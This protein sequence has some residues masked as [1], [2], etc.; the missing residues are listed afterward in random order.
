MRAA[1]IDAWLI[2]DFRGN[3][4]ALARVLQAK[5]WTTRRAALLI[6]R[7]GD[8]TL[9]CHAIDQGQLTPHFPALKVYTSWQ[10]F[11]ALLR[12]SLSGY[13]RVAMEYAPGA[14]LPVVG[15]VDAGTV[16]LIRSFGVEVVSSADLAQVSIARWDDAAQKNH[17]HAS[18]ITTSIM[19]GA[20]E[21]IRTQRKAGQEIREHQVQRY[22]V[23]RFRSEG[24]EFGE[25][26]IV[27]VNEHGSDPH[28][29]VSEKT[30]K[31]VREG[32]WVLIDLWARVPGEENVYSDIS[33]V[34]CAGEPTPRHREVYAAVK[35]ARDAA[36]AFAQ[37]AHASGTPAQ[38]WQV[39][40]A[41]REQLLSRG[42]GAF[43]KHRTGHSL[44][45]GP[46]VHGL[47]VN[48]DSVETHDTRRLL[49][50]LGFTIEPGLY[51]GP[52]GVRL[53]INVFVDQARGPILT[54]CLQ[55]D[56]VRV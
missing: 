30:S 26:P 15:I 31:P 9:L 38:G 35:A 41:A 32:D 33:W 10:E 49:P 24:L 56:I 27:A 46:L 19:A 23:D 16:E 55:D 8:V 5:V 2:H 18:A 37:S 6:P 54:S 3:N 14:M 7:E 25:P 4:P 29:E 17:R 51:P 13:P 28:F 52:F 34:A 22:I 36:L 42:M 45:P 39:D 43:I 12:A 48:I 47:G 40:A 20:F 53:E 11:Q 1:G 21:L 44:S 50:G